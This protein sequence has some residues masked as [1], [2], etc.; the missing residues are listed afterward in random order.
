MEQENYVNCPSCDHPNQV[1][2][3]LQFMSFPD[4]VEPIVQF[5]EGELNVITCP[6]CRQRVPLGSPL[7]VLNSEFKLL[8]VVMPEHLRSEI[9]NSLPELPE[10]WTIKYCNNYP[11]LYQETAPWFNTTVMPVLNTILS[12]TYFDQPAEEQVR[13]LSPLILHIFKSQLDGRLIES[14]FKIAGQ[15]D[16][17]K[18]K[19]FL[20]Q[21]Y[22]ST[23]TNLIQQ[24]LHL[25][26]KAREIPLLDATIREQ[27]PS[28]CLT[29]EV[30]AHT[31]KE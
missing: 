28:I 4:D 22:V 31:L 11:E 9:E 17:E 25:A 5:Y 20:E 26:L 7:A 2:D 3:L 1:P 30:L 21:L 15:A 13:K 29:A 18:H 6:V 24:L 23:L 16:T 14:I 10:D 8:I 19:K 12:G 27:I